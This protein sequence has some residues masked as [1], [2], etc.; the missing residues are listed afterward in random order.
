MKCREELK[1][2]FFFKTT[3][4]GQRS[5]LRNEIVKKKQMHNFVL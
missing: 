5:V 4:E 2:F 1:F 3:S